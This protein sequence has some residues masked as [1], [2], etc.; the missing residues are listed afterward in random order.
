MSFTGTTAESR[1]PEEWRLLM[2]RFR[3]RLERVDVS[4]V[5]RTELQKRLAPHVH[6][7]LWMPMEMDWETWLRR[8]WLECI[9]GRDL[10]GLRPGEREHAAQMQEG[11]DAGWIAYLA[12]HSSK[13]KAEQLGWLGK[14]WGIWG[15][16]RFKPI[17][18]EVDQELSG[19][20]M[21]MVKRMLRRWRRAEMIR[22][23]PGE[24][25]MLR[26]FFMPTRR[27]W[28]EVDGLRA[29][30]RESHTMCLRSCAEGRAQYRRIF[31]SVGALPCVGEVVRA[32]PAAVPARLVAW[33]MAET[34]NPF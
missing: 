2:H 18:P 33:A 16:A 6:A 13:H 31:A 12:G 1:N 19:R 11:F 22:S 7:P 3:M 27:R 30:F 34:A 26:A 21:A 9:G 14:Q 15:R 29:S 25:A 5:W 32:Y 4:G 8:T 24:L 23:L 10:R 17:A 28:V 20:G